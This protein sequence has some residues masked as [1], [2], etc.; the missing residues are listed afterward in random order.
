MR[1]ENKRWHRDGQHFINTKQS[2]NLSQI[3]VIHTGVDTVKE[4]YQC[5]LK[6]NVLEDIKALYDSGE[7]TIRIDG[8][9]WLVSKSSK[10][11]GYQWILRNNDIGLVVLLKSFYLEEDLHGSHIKIEGSPHLINGMTPAE[12]SA[13]TL[14]V[15]H[16]FANQILSIGCAAHLAVDL[17]NWKPDQNFEYALVTRAK[18]KMSFSGISQADFNMSETASI[19]GDRQTFTFGSASSVQ[20]CVY[21]KVSEIIKSD[22]VDYWEKQWKKTPSVNDV[23]ESEYS[24]GDQVTRIEGRL[25]HSVVQQFCNATKD[26]NGDFIQITNFSDL[27]NHL[28]A[29]WRYILNNFRLH[30]STTYVHPLWQLLEE[31]VQFFKPAPDLIYKR[32]QKTPNDNT[33]RK[34]AIWL[35]NTIRLYSRKRFKRDFVIERILKSGFDEELMDYFGLFGYEGR[36]L[37]PDVIHEFVHQ[38]I[39]RLELEGIAA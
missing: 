26:E 6:K 14:K 23:F 16:T 31:D 8:Y 21:D 32:G 36:Y 9:P 12:Y 17:K 38:K 34:V 28:T 10:K 24:R 4:L 33:K 19:Y 30:H 37:L 20:L 39:D 25:H 7:Q 35:G 27:S 13:L 15:A 1:Y 5:L 3:R 2:F 29:L 11:A 22:K 18:R